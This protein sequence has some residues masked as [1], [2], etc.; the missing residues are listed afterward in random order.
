MRFFSC[1]ECGKQLLSTEIKYYTADQGNCF[2]D[3]YCSFDWHVKHSKIYKTNE[4][5]DRPAD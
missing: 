2:C 4:Q 3:A 5:D 1:S